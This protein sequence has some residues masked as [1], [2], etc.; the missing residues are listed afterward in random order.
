VSNSI[1]SKGL[2]SIVCKN[3]T[4]SFNRHPI[5]HH[6]NCE[7]KMNTSTA[8]I[9]SNGAG[10]STLLKALIGLISPESGSIELSSI[11]NQDI[12]YLPQINDLDLSMPLTV[13]DLVLIGSWHNI[14]LFH[15]PKSDYLSQINYALNEVGLYNFNKKYINELSSGQ[16]QRVLFARIILQNSKIVILDEPFNAIDNETTNDLLKLLKKWETKYQKTV[17]TVLHDMKQVKDY[18]NYTLFLSKKLAVYDTTQNIFNNAKISL[19][20]GL[21]INYDDNVICSIK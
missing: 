9:G 19:T 17:I 4:I 10:K 5:I 15:K 14:G 1:N 16:L 18:F 21:N 8:I 3:L 12:S 11:T 20:N 2:M 6:L 13:E 7:F